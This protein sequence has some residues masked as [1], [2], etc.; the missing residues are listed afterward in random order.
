M[1]DE[2]KAKILVI[3][4][5]PDLRETLVDLLEPQYSVKIAEDGLV[6]LKSALREPPDLI[7][8]DLRMPNMDGFETCKLLRADSEFDSIPI[9]V[10]SG[11]VSDQDRVKVLEM[12]A[13]DFIGKP[14]NSSELLLRLQKRLAART[15]T[16]PRGEISTHSEEVITYGDLV[17]NVSTQL[18]TLKGKELHFS[19]LEF[20]ILHVLLMNADR[21]VPRDKLIEMIWPN[22]EVSSRIIDAHMVSVR[23]KLKSSMIKIGSVYGKGYRLSL[24][25]VDR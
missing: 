16:A 21:I 7:L 9:V 17:V 2:I 4:D 22:Q 18:V 25:K 6:G 5:D 13:D 1:S 14:F 3:E 20:S 12:G 19:Q 15:T 11:F 24:I 10:L 8:M 23:N